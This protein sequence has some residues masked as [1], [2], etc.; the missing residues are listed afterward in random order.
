MQDREYKAQLLDQRVELMRWAD[1]WY[2][3]CGPKP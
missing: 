3:L 2:Y 1:R